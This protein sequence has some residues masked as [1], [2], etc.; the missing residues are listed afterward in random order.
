MI[1]INYSLRVAYKAALDGIS[2]IPVFYQTVP[3]TVSPDQYIV[4][5][6]ITSSDASTNNSSDTETQITVELHTWNDGLN[7]GLSADLVAREVYNRIYPYPNI[8]LSIDGAQIVSTR[9]VNDVVQD[10]VN[11]GNRQYI[12][13]YI[14][15]KHT[16]FQRSDIS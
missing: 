15:F 2:G 7:S 5:R 9:M 16:I 10:A 1:D 11:V 6:T 13:R 12:S 3:P 4:F 14:T 8:N